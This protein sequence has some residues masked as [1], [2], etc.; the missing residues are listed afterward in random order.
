MKRSRYSKEQ[1][2]LALR[3]AESGTS[4][5]K[6]EAMLEMAREKWGNKMLIFGGVPSVML[7]DDVLE[8]DQFSGGVSTTR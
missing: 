2:A 1:I 5:V 8:V 3:Q 7:E 4:V 6:C